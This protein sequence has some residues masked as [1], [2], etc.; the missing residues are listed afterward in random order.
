LS[1][2]LKRII[3]F[4]ISLIL[5]AST[6]GCV[7]SKKDC[8]AD[9]WQ[10]I[11]YKDGVRGQS[12][13][14]IQQYAATCA[15]HGVTPDALAYTAGF[16]VGIVEYCAPANGFKQGAG[17]DDYNGVCPAQLEVAFLKQ[18]ISGLRN[19]MDELAIRHDK[20]SL[21]L[22][23]LRDHRDWLIS[24]EAPHTKEDKQIEETSSSLTLN[25]TERIS[26]N[27]KI[28]RWSAGLE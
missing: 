3:I 6:S 1:I 4:S 14:V 5:I 28:R 18:Y 22:D 12:P 16:D 17:N 9:D 11:G 2:S 25:A 23:E 13:D 21:R 20:D 27:D 19:A 26:I 15:K 7:I 24:E 10:T 8:L